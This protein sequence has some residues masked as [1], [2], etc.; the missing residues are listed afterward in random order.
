[1]SLLDDA[2]FLM[3]LKNDCGYLLPTPMEGGRYMAIRPFLF[4]HAI[5]TGKMGDRTSYDDR[6]CY[7]SLEAAL[8]AF[9]NWD[10]TGEPAGWHRHPGTGRRRSETGKEYVEF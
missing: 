3:W 5:V 9:H 1:M 10:G 4:T 6:W 8:V 2:E 7:H